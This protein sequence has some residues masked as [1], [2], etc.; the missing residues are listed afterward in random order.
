[1]ELMVLLVALVA[2]LAACVGVLR[3]LACEFDRGLGA[4]ANGAE[5]ARRIRSEL[6]EL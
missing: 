6:V 3:L 5:R 4:C 2:A 1:M